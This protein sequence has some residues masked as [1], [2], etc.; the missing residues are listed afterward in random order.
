M[1]GDARGLPFKDDCFDLVISHAS[2]P[3][4]FAPYRDHKT[5]EVIPIEGEVKERA[6]QDVLRVLWE[7][8]RVV[9]KRGQIRMSTFSESE[10]AEMVLTDKGERSQILENGEEKIISVPE[11]NKQMFDRVYLIKKALELFERQ[12]GAKCIFKDE[13]SGGLIIIMKSL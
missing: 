5:G 12:S 3:H 2:M 6:L 7:A 4:L 10:I 11:D 1:V 8:Y 13:K 9:K